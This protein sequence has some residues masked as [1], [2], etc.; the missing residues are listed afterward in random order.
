M[1]YTVQEK[2]MT[3]I[4]HCLRTWRYYLLSSKFVIMT[5]NVA[6][7]YFQMQKNF[8][9]K[10]ARGQESLAELEY[11][12][13]Y[14]F[15]KANVVADAL[16]RRTNLALIT[17]RTPQSDLLGRIREKMQMIP[18][19]KTWQRYDNSGWKI[20]CSWLLVIVN[21]CWNGRTFGTSGLTMQE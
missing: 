3:T 6:T 15:G 5:N 4:I 17:M 7:S 20:G 11:C 21:S 9:P 19:P 14:K 1:C 2:K 13:Q 16:G 8:R 12:L 10:Q 18:W